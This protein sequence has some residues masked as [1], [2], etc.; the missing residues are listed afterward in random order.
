VSLDGLAPDQRAVVQL[1]LQQDRSYEDLAGMLGIS[2]DAVRERARRGL[3]SLADPG[4]LDDVQ[5]ADL[6]DYLLGQQSGA[7]R[8]HARALLATSDTAR[9]WARAVAGQLS[10]VARSPLPE[11][12][13]DPA[14]AAPADPYPEPAPASV[15][16]AALGEAID[17]EPDAAEADADPAPVR[18]RPRPRPRVPARPTRKPR[19]REAA[20]AAVDAAPH[21]SGG[22]PR[23]SRLGG[24]LL[25]GGVAIVLAAL[26][27]WIATKGGDDSKKAAA[28]APTA[29][30]TPE[31]QPIG[32]LDL[33]AANGG[34]A[35]GEMVVFASSAGGVAFTVTGTGL[36]A[37]KAGEAYAVWLVGGA[38]P[39]WLGFAPPVKDDGKFGT[40]GPREDDAGNFAKWL[41]EAKQVVVSR[42]TR[43]GAAQ[44]GPIVLSGA[45]S[46]SNNKG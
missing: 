2:A 25:I 26:V 6:A 1:V 27:V 39:H 45:V 11:I 46:A 16:G 20:A 42:E 38:K 43:E 33:K 9:A 35:K 19:D 12:P 44:P 15:A 7:R 24:A 32:K 17:D 22:G 36:P 34:K 14:P 41:A 3:D 30:A 40:S 4:G 10:A 8:E 31:F 29:T 37:T 18:A 5:R 28:P 23:S 13:E 21:P